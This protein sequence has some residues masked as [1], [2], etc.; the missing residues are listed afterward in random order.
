MPCCRPR[1]SYDLTQCGSS[2]AGG[3]PFRFAS[4]SAW[5]ARVWLRAWAHRPPLRPAHWASMSSHPRA[6][7]LPASNTSLDTFTATERDLEMKMHCYRFLPR[8]F[9]VFALPPPSR[10][11]RSP[12]LIGFSRKKTVQKTKTSLCGKTAR[13]YS[14]LEES[15][16]GSS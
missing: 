8:Q 3:R 10:Y 7:F 15:M 5:G 9:S 14:I 16:V 13:V 2:P 6:A 4:R 11:A 1:L 12:S